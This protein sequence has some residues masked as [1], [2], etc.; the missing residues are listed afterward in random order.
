MLQISNKKWL[1]FDITNK[2][3]LV[4]FSKMSFIVKTNQ[5]WVTLKNSMIKAC[6]KHKHI[7]P[8]RKG[9]FNTNNPLV[10]Q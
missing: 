7:I 6:V 10:V 4:F 2:I 9:Y 8:N 3:L 1:V 5:Y